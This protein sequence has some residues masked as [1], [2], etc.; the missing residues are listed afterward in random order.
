MQADS[1]LGNVHNKTP[2]AAVSFNFGSTYLQHLYFKTLINYGNQ[3]SSTNMATRFC[4]LGGQQNLL[5]SSGGGS[6]WVSGADW[7]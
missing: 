7:E 2:I 6:F 5:M 1:L 4:S 3:P